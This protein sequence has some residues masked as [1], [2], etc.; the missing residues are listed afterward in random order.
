M[1]RGA[2]ALL[3]A[4]GSAHAE[5]WEVRVPDKVDIVVGEPGTSFS[6]NGVKR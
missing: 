2:L 1:K 5:S 3:L 4:T 6:S